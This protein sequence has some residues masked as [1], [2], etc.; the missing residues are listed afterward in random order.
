VAISLGLAGRLWKSPAWASGPIVLISIDTL[1]A[2]HLPTYGYRAVR[3][4]T[5]DAL[6][7]DGIV[8]ENAYAHSPQTLPSH[9]SILSGRLPFEHGVRDNIGFAV[10][11]GETLLPTMLREA[12]FSSGGFVSAYVLR[13]ETGIANGFDHFDAR[14][15]PSSPEIA[16]GELQRDGAATLAAVDR[17]LDGLT[18]P[19]F[20]LFFHIYEP[21]S[22]YT[23][24]GRFSAY[25][26]YDGEIAYA[27][28]IV[29]GL[30]G[31]FKRRG[32]YDAALIVMLS[33][34]GEGLGDHG[35]QEHG[36]FLYR[37]AIRVPLLIKLPRQQSAGR[38]VAT[39]VQH[40]D[41]VPTILDVSKLSPRPALQGRSLRPL[42]TGGTIAE[43]G[44]YAEALYSRYHFGWSELYALTD[45]RYSFIRAPREELYDLQRDPGER[46]NLASDREST[47]V[48]MRNALE[49]LSAGARIDAPGDVS[50]EARERLRALGYVGAAPPAVPSPAAGLPDP[51]E[52]VQVLERYRAAIALVRQGR[53]EAG[54]SQFRAIVADNP[55]MADV[56][57]EIGGLELRLGRPEDALGAYKR[58]VDV[59]PHDPAAL[60]SVAD[61]L[62]ALGRVEE[63]RA[64]AALAAESIP[65][66]DVRWRAKAHQSLAM[67]A[68]ARHDDSGARAEARIAHEIDP[69]LPA[70][71]Y[72]DGLIRY[73]ANQ[74]DIA[75]PFLEQALKESAAR[76]VQIPELRYHLGDALARLERYSEAE[77]LLTEEVRLFPYELRARAA[78]A[79]LYRATGRARE[80]D[81]EVETIERLAPT[82]EGRALVGKLR[83]MFRNQQVS[84]PI[85]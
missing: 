11:P 80:S 58:L 36:L 82:P 13:D 78:L 28:E 63:A 29:G 61:T 43:K 26:P 2:D 69:T 34:H 10:K 65:A 18:S 52:K 37:E 38:R 59:A 77:P 31:S 6:A 60:I 55:M 79:M 74:F 17:W 72:V 49:Q 9:V 15:P 57:S 20:F 27:D 41:V 40:I 16:V 30:I 56:W 70:P 14:L 42:F 71:Q 81:R 39:P 48:A 76:T 32:L 21:H 85:P 50:A 8:F 83:R 66:N 67:V 46:Q 64:Q 5:I 51:K 73:N 12:G 84:R 45:A 7:A 4:P 68:L 35:E 53:F 25:T 22:P 75:V 1:R 3:T 44:L 33:D 62:L 47:R 54:L 24:P 23:P 19:R